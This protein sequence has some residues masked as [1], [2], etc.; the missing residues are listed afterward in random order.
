MLAEPT[1]EGFAKAIKELADNPE[2]RERLGAAGRAFVE[3]DFTFPAHCRRMA[4]LYK[5]VAD[6]VETFPDG[7]E[8][9]IETHPEADNYQI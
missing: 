4:E 7:Y 6:T 9:G 2:L 3:K 5:M 1:P 8:H